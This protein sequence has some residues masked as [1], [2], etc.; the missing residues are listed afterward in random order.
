MSD[1]QMVI[2]TGA[3]I[4]IGEA[5]AKAFGRAGW[6]VVVTDVLED[7][8]RATAHDVVAA[9]GSA[10]FH[11][12][13]VTSTSAVEHVVKQVEDAR[14]P[15]SAAIA[16]AGIAHRVPLAELTDEKWAHTLD[17]DLTGEFRLARAVAPGMAKGGGGAIA[18]VSSVMGTTYGW[19]DHV[20]YNAAKSGVVGLVRGLA[21]DLAADQ[22]RVNALAP[23]F[24]RT[25]QALSTV[26]SVGPEGLEKAADY[27]PLGRIGEPE[28]M[29]DVLLF[30]CSDASR[31]MTGQTIIVDGGLTV[32]R[33]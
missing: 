23:G 27:I 26:H 28:E 1:T 25:A 29:A 13:D 24:I 12:L 19:H 30:L 14:G 9:G 3:G 8:G 21:C 16:N 31:Y 32:G 15:F 17:I 11:P 18:C 20:Q 33:Y 4:G 5:T 22:I 7:E 6:H 10:E 2:I